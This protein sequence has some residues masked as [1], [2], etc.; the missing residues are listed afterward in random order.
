MGEKLGSKLMT[1]QLNVVKDF[2]AFQEAEQDKA[3]G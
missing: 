1:K 2:M 3:S